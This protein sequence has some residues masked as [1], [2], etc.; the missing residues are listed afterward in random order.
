MDNASIAGRTEKLRREIELIQQEEI[1]Y[2]SRR[3]HSSGAKTEHDTRAL[4]LL[5][6]RGELLTLSLRGGQPN[7]PPSSNRHFN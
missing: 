4:R 1:D 5:A 3:A 6:I 7:Y 2:R